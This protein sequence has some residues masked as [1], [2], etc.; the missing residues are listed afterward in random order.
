LDK[1]IIIFTSD[2]GDMCGEHGRVDKS[3][4]LDGSMKV[5]FIVYAPFLIATNLVVQEAVSNIDIFPTLVDL[6]GMSGMPEVD[7]TSLAPLLKGTADYEGRNLVF[8]RSA[9]DESGWIAATTDRYKLVVST[10][11][12]DKPW[13]IDKQVDPD[14]LV[15]F[16]DSISYS[17][18]KA[19]ML[20]KLIWYCE[21]NEDP[22]FLNIK[23][24]QDLGVPPLQTDTTHA[25]I[26]KN[27]FFDF[28]S[29]GWSLNNSDILFEMNPETEI[30]GITCRMPGV[31]NSRIIKQNVSV[32][33][34]TASQF[35]FKGRIQNA[36]GA[37]GTQPNEHASSGIA[38]L[39]GEVLSPDNSLLL[40]LTT[41][42]PQT[43]DLN[44]EFTTSS[45]HTSVS[46]VLSKNWNIAYV[47][48]VFLSE[49][50]NTGTNAL[51][52]EEMIHLYQLQQGFRIIASSQ[53]HTAKVL[54]LTGR[55]IRKYYNPGLSVDVEPI[56]NGMYIASVT[57]PE[58]ISINRKYL[59]TN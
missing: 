2:H 11:S 35:G 27:G 3:V 54:D 42:M 4:P 9:R 49:I 36:V 45:E 48:E 40:D 43:T 57:F 41:Q 55:L 28:G 44:G 52:L 21:E 51:Q 10:V 22:K 25:N 46:V 31:N 17:E 30:N 18:V 12:A 29:D 16:F 32:K 56:Q 34:N 47:D 50:T 23:I 37:S 1:T 53:I 33:P 19:Y 24:R 59:V 5:P 26:I 38:T 13:L 14:E 7:G 15:N 8:S 58:G 39:K 20:E 6:C